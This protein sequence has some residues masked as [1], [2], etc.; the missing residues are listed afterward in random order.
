MTNLRDVTAM[1]SEQKC[2]FVCCL[3]FGRSA[4]F[5]FCISSKWQKSQKLLSYFVYLTDPTSLKEMICL[6][7]LS[8]IVLGKKIQYL[9]DF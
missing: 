6:K 5:I 4:I 7:I 9:I 1:I 3:L 8:I 2:V